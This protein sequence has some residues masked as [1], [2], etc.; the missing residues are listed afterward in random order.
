VPHHP[1]D[2]ERSG[3]ESELC[4]EDGKLILHLLEFGFGFISSLTTLGVSFGMTMT[5]VMF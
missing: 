2:L 3:N 4:W 5:I 1:S